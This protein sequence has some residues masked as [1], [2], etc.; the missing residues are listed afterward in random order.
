MIDHTRFHPIRI[1][2]LTRESTTMMMSSSS[3]TSAPIAEEESGSNKGFLWALFFII[4]TLGG[5]AYYEY[6]DVMLVINREDGR[7]ALMEVVAKQDAYFEKEKK[8]AT[9]LQELG[10]TEVKD[11]S[12]DS[13][14]GLYRILITEGDGA[15]YTLAAEPQ[16]EQTGDSKC[17]PLTYASKGRAKSSKGTNSSACW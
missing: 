14:K 5:N 12:I 7:A 9:T 10:Y 13:P 16:G 15:F 8:Y 4:L 11:F 6:A 17:A 1:I 2:S 3:S